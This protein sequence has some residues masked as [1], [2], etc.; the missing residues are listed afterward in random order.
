M[1]LNEESWL[2]FKF[3]QRTARGMLEQPQEAQQGM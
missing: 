3:L 2:F 1:N